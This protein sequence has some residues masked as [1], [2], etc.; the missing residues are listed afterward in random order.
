MRCN[1]YISTNTPV[2]VPAEKHP[3]HAR[4]PPQ[5]K[6]LAPPRCPCQSPT[7]P[8]P[9]LSICS[10]A[11]GLEQRAIWVRLPASSG[12]VFTQKRQLLFNICLPR[13]KTSLFTPLN[14][15]PPPH[16]LSLPPSS[17]SS[18][19]LIYCHQNFPYIR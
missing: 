8:F 17:S 4:P 2:P 18:H 15:P 7:P 12:G 9:S 19:S 10:L 1:Q 5:K 16:F 11:L 13:S 14:S 3:H 6:S